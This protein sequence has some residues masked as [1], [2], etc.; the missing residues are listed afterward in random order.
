LLATILIITSGGISI[1]I[2]AYDD[3]SYEKEQNTDKKYECRTGPFEGFFVSSPEFC[4]VKV[5]HADKN[6][7][8]DKSTLLVKKELVS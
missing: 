1:Q 7:N 5:N 3:L 8:N 4:N 2:L 6:N